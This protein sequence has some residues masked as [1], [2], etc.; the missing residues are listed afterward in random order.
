MPK[1]NSRQDGQ[2]LIGH[3]DVFRDIN[4]AEDPSGTN[5]PEFLSE[6][7]FLLNKAVWQFK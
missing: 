5:D 4:A 7:A 3:L 2:G 1:L 6:Y